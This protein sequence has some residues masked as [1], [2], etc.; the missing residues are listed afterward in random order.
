MK[1][2]ISLIVLIIVLMLTASFSYSEDILNYPYSNCKGNINFSDGCN[3]KIDSLILGQLIKDR[4]NTLTSSELNS[5]RGNY[6]INNHGS[7]L[8]NQ[9][10]VMPENSSVV[11]TIN[12]DGGDN[13]S[14]YFLKFNRFNKVY[15]YRITFPEALRSNVDGGILV[16]LENKKISLLDKEYVIRNTRVSGLNGAQDIYMELYSGEIIDV[17]EANDFKIY[18]I[19][20]V[21][22]ELNLTFL[23]D[24]SCSFMIN[25]E[26]TGIMTRGDLFRLSDGVWFWIKEVDSNPIIYLGASKIIIK[27]ETNHDWASLNGSDTVEYFYAETS[28]MIDN[29]TEIVVDF[30]GSGSINDSS[31]FIDISE[32]RFYW[33][34]HDDYYVSIGNLL[35]SEL[36]SDVKINLFSRN[37][38]FKFEGIE[39]NL[40]DEINLIPL[41]NKLKMTL[42]TKTS[43][44]FTFDAMYSDSA[45][46]VSGFGSD[47]SKQIKATTSGGGTTVDVGLREKVWLSSDKYSHLIE[48]DRIGSDR[49]RF[50]NV[51]SGATQEV[52]VA[53]GLSINYG[54][55]IFDDKGY[56]FSH[57]GGAIVRFNTGQGGSNNDH[58]L[59]SDYK[60]FIV[61]NGLGANGD[62]LFFTKE[63]G[64]VILDIS[65]KDILLFEQMLP[66]SENIS[67]VQGLK[68]PISADFET[69]IR[70]TGHIESA[71]EEGAGE[72]HV[73]SETNIDS[74]NGTSLYGTLFDQSLDNEGNISIFYPSDDYLSDNIL[75]DVYALSEYITSS[76]T[77]FENSSDCLNS[78]FLCYWKDSDSSC[79]PIERSPS[80]G[81]GDG[82]PSGCN[83][84]IVLSRSCTDTDGGIDI[85]N[86]GDI[87]ASVLYEGCGSSGGGSSG[88]GSSGGGS[89]G[90]MT[91]YCAN[92][93]WNDNTSDW[94]YTHVVFC[95]ANTNGSSIECGVREGS[96]NATNSSVVSY[97][98]CAEGCFN[99]ACN[100]CSDGVKNG[101]E[102]DVDC[103]GSCGGCPINKIC[104]IDSDCES[105]NCIDGSCALAF[106]WYE[107]YYLPN[108]SINRTV[109]FLL[110][111]FH[112]PQAL[113]NSSFQNEKGIFNYTQKL[114][115]NNLL[116][117]Y[118][119]YLNEP[120]LHHI[121]FRNFIYEYKV[122]FSSPIQSDRVGTTLDD[123]E[124]KSL[125]LFGEQYD[126]LIAEKNISY[127]VYLKISNT[128]IQDTLENNSSKTYL[129]RFSNYTVT[130]VI[131]N[132]TAYFTINGE[133]TPPMQEKDSYI[134]PDGIEFYVKT[135][136]ENQGDEFDRDIVEFMFIYK[137]I[138][139]N[140]SDVY[141]NG[142]DVGM[143]CF[144]SYSSS[145]NQFYLHQI[146]FFWNSYDEYYVKMGG[147][148]IDKVP[149][150]EENSLLFSNLNIHYEN[151]TSPETEEIVLSYNDYTYELLFN[152]TSK[153]GDNISFTPFYYD[154]S[155]MY[156][157]SSDDLALKIIPGE[158]IEEDNIFILSSDGYTYLMQVDRF[159]DSD[160]IVR[161]KNLGTGD[162]ISVS[163]PGC[164][165]EGNQI[166][167][168]SGSL[169]IGGVAYDFTADCAD[170]NGGLEAV[171][172][173]SYGN[174]FTLP[175][176]GL[177][178][179]QNGLT[180]AFDT[181]G[182]EGY[183]RLYE[184]QV[185][186]NASWNQIEVYSSYNHIYIS[187][188]IYRK[189]PETSFYSY[190]D[191]YPTT[192]PIPNLGTGISYYYIDTSMSSYGT[193]F[194]LISNYPSRAMHI[195]FPVEQ[196]RPIVKITAHENS[197]LLD[198][199]IKKP[200][201]GECWNSFS[202]IWSKENFGL[203]YNC[204]DKIPKEASCWLNSGTGSDTRDI[205]YTILVP[206]PDIRQCGRDYARENDIPIMQIR[207]V[208]SSWEI[209]EECYN[210]EWDYDVRIDTSYTCNE[211]EQDACELI[212]YCGWFSE[213]TTY[214][215]SSILNSNICVNS[216]TLCDELNETECSLSLG[217]CSWDENSSCDFVDTCLNLTET[218]CSVAY[219][220]GCRWTNDSCAIDRI[221]A[222]TG[223]GGGSSGGGGTVINSI[224]SVSSDDSIVSLFST[225]SGGGGS[226]SISTG[227]SGSNLYQET[228]SP[229]TRYECYAYQNSYN[230]AQIIKI[231]GTEY[232]QY[233]IS[234]LSDD[235][236]SISIK[237]PWSC[238]YENIFSPIVF[239]AEITGNDTIVTDGFPQASLVTGRIVMEDNTPFP[240]NNIRYGYVSA[241]IISSDHHIYT[242]VH[243]RNDHC[244]YGRPLCINNNQ[245]LCNA[246]FGCQWDGVNCES[247]FEQRFNSSY[248]Y[249][250]WGIKNWN[251][252][253]INCE[254]MDGYHSDDEQ[255]CNSAGCSWNQGNNGYFNMS[256]LLAGEYQFNFYY[257]T[258]EGK[259]KSFN[260]I[261]NISGNGTVSAPEDLGTI[262]YGEGP[263]IVGRVTT[264]N[265]TPLEDVWVSVRTKVNYSKPYYWRDQ[266]YYSAETDAQ[267]EYKIYGMIPGTYKISI[268][269]NYE[270]QNLIDY[271][272]EV[273]VG[274]TKITKNITLETGRQISGVI[275]DSLGNPII[276]VSVNAYIPW[277][278]NIFDDNGY[279]LTCGHGYSDYDI[280]DSQGRYTLKGLRDGTYSL[281]VYPN[282][283]YDS[284]LSVYFRTEKTIVL[285]GTDLVEDFVLK[286]GISI[287]GTVSDTEGNPV[288]C[289]WVSAWR[290][291]DNSTDYYGTY[292]YAEITANGTFLLPRLIDDKTYTLSIYP[293]SDYVPK[294]VDVTLNGSRHINIRLGRGGSI[295]GTVVNKE[296]IPL[297]N[298]YV[299]S[300][301]SYG[302]GWGSS[303]TKSD[304]SFLIKGLP[305][306]SQNNTYVLSI[307][308]N[309]YV[310]YKQDRIS[311]SEGKTTNV[312][313]LE[314]E[315]GNI[316]SGVIT[317]AGILVTS[318]LYVNYWSSENKFS[319][320]T[321]SPTGNYSIK[322]VPDGTYDV[323]IWIWD[324]RESKRIR[325]VSVSGNTIKNIEIAQVHLNVTGIISDTEG[326]LVNATVNIYSASEVKGGTAIS[327]IFG[328]YLV[329]RL[330]PAEDYSVTVRK[331]GYHTNY[332]SNLQFNISSTEY[333]VQ[334]QIVEDNLFNVSGNITGNNVPV[335]LVAV[336]NDDSLKEKHIVVNTTDYSIRGLSVGNY[337]VHAVHGQTKI[338]YPEIV[339]PGNNR[340][341]DFDFS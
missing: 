5:L 71:T 225:S 156:L 248:Y 193:I 127:P 241:W 238:S 119:N 14:N 151:I 197:T 80:S 87:S 249:T 294:N 55:F 63:E 58:P 44:I 118:A 173:E 96:C 273:I 75:F 136:L 339:S 66:G 23:E 105:N 26:S 162:L 22:Y 298:Q 244:S 315:K 16:D 109:S 322:G 212:S 122:E 121:K 182:N 56:N 24:N 230:G 175:G 267:G 332:T 285:N 88:G 25:G 30:I 100:A 209:P 40:F 277:K 245:T 32:I 214:V 271:Q 246:T 326:Y 318:S 39:T 46:I 120:Q 265:G 269:S 243:L 93:F 155:I 206:V 217:L 252:D 65:E 47:S 131:N 258:L 115:I 324:S 111:D 334:L 160:E 283:W 89:S 307:S 220:Y 292:S 191:N 301:V 11:Y 7:F 37:I 128:D 216:Y 148:L 190:L 29:M 268:W 164:S 76:C 108:L 270:N 306:S 304:G 51:A 189:F 161:F 330:V 266:K 49:V 48:I 159:F 95:H 310:S 256:G 9:Y 328:R 130:P 235:N 149:V 341:I 317:K 186:E 1:K 178:K 28:N 187:N 221:I 168:S 295:S 213:N 320:S 97:H 27:E 224:K 116:L 104:Y 272:S 163:V 309:E 113:K 138:E 141:V 202:C 289:G 36:D 83:T 101:N 140:G 227:G 2:I 290:S 188:S 296:G 254:W 110:T 166:N 333:D 211:L 263:G 257:Y 64:L 91:D 98:Y 34:N 240:R 54:S 74:R 207:S 20:G 144:I 336:N 204:E 92:R 70:V 226:G 18:T 237:V 340:D 15:N 133:I 210:W 192:Y 84:S 319:K 260:K 38:D 123:I 229:P 231:N 234:N 293:C 143:D 280:T 183:L 308:S 286:E 259:Y 242:D 239:T 335:V 124:G 180:I 57:D 59:G 33:I 337:S 203:S 103:G 137:S 291:M 107:E 299:Y 288:N 274:N 261:I 102:T 250:Q 174:D 172:F 135:I 4:I 282:I 154:D 276:G 284:S 146:L 152:F 171:A 126:I 165:D 21:D 139:I 255:D 13:D 201:E 35:S 313:T 279:C 61:D 327:D 158:S 53:S 208:D 198:I 200:T 112:F 94:D 50:K 264:E 134:L 251:I 150:K 323:Y 170:Y 8:Y 10:I 42:R 77:S 233:I 68:I 305:A 106:P 223:G 311:V 325:N 218:D 329:E 338:I 72:N 19:D 117:R 62:A 181:D 17:L 12:P 81:S 79:I 222:L 232:Y 31:G 275:T 314:L 153:T 331:D 60:D 297:S 145:S 176:Y 125:F 6:I 114:R 82:M 41:S 281:D 236:Y 303:I 129:G 316:V 253:Y 99:G 142:Q 52:T 179:T 262:V 90:G 167:L 287:T 132:G 184:G 196:K 215:N 45:F 205:T 43:D 157:G 321:Y 312:G 169:I 86:K 185:D 219:D 199:C 228:C 85:F 194:R 3:E 69:K 147:S 300:W 67:Y 302:N 195:G 278:M 73:I 247:H 78:S 177:V